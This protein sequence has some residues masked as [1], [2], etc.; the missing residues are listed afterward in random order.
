MEH[1]VR[2]FTQRTLPGKYRRFLNTPGNWDR[3]CRGQALHAHMGHH[4]LPSAEI[5]VLGFTRGKEG[6]FDHIE[7]FLLGMSSRFYTPLGA[8][9]QPVCRAPRMVP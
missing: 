9:V 2:A 8:K 7:G 3:M 6:K 1:R 5:I 4:A